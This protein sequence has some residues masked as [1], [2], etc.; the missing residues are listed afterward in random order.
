L[1]NTQG[2]DTLEVKGARGKGAVFYERVGET[3]ASEFDCAMPGH[4]PRLC[5]NHQAKDFSVYLILSCFIGREPTY[6]ANPG[7]NSRAVL[8]I[9]LAK[10]TVP[11][12]GDAV[13]E[14][15][16]KGFFHLKGS[17]DFTFSDFELKARQKIG[18]TRKSR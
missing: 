17:R 9:T 8:K 2:T 16:D 3:A 6:E 4:G 13:I 12:D 10:V 11:F 18:G 14:K 7:K 5:Q 1:P 15:D